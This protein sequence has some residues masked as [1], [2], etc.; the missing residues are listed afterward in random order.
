[1][2]NKKKYGIV[3][4]QLEHMVV[5][6]AGNRVVSCPTEHEAQEYI[7]GVLHEELMVFSYGNGGMDSED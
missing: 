4:C 2:E 3:P 7:E 1:M 5:D 6:A